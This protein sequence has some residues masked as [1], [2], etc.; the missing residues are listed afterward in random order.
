MFIGPGPVGIL[1]TIYRLRRIMKPAGRPSAL[2]RQ[3]FSSNRTA[4]NLINTL[5]LKFKTLESQ[6]NQF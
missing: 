1:L 3:Q 5:Q 2:W 4:T 6:Y